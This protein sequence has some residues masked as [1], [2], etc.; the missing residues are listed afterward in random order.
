MRV[1]LILS[2][3]VFNISAIPA[4]WAGACDIVNSTLTVATADTGSRV[5]GSGSAYSMSASYSTSTSVDAKG[6]F[7]KTSDTY[8]WNGNMLTFMTF[9]LGGASYAHNGSGWVSWDGNVDNLPTYSSISDTTSEISLQINNGTL[10]AGTYQ[11]FFGYKQQA[12]LPKP[13]CFSGYIYYYN[14]TPIS[15]TIS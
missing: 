5:S 2:L 15:V 11:V 8:A 1:N 3:L 4:A 7:Y 10:S 9:T 6:S 14:A 13:G 12:D